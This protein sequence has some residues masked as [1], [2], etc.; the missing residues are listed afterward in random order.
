MSPPSPHKRKGLVVPVGSVPGA[1]GGML[2]KGWGM[3]MEAGM[4]TFT[5]TPPAAPAPMLGIT[6]PMGAIP[7][8]GTMVMGCVGSCVGT[9]E[10]DTG[11]AMLL[12]PAGMGLTRI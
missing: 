10:R 9:E 3:D 4:P 2:N 5:P 11:S 7:A 8:M 1:W 6:R 12:K